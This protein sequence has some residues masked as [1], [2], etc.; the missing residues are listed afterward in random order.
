MKTNIL[1]C[2]DKVIGYCDPLE[3]GEVSINLVDD[4]SESG[5]KFVG[6]YSCF[7]SWNGLTGNQ[8]KLGELLHPDLDSYDIESCDKE[9]YSIPGLTFFLNGLPVKSG[10]D[11]IK[12]PGMTFIDEE[13]GINIWGEKTLK[14]DM[15]QLNKRIFDAFKIP[16]KYI[17]LPNDTD[18]LKS[19]RDIKR[20]KWEWLDPIDK[21]DWELTF[22]PEKSIDSIYIDPSKVT[23]LTLPSSP[24]PGTT[25]EIKNLSD[26]LLKVENP[27]VNNEYENALT[28]IRKL[29]DTVNHLQVKVFNLEKKLEDYFSLLTL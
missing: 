9:D 21:E 4:D 3:H 12:E 10:K 15:F 17:G 14:S 29:Q 25:I 2:D 11:S 18:L 24:K 16:E 7:N 19:L 8:Y 13:I 20:V 27:K 22:K 5:F 26:N 1:D 28:L 23:T 6:C